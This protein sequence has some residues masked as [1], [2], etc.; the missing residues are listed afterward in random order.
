VAS[1]NAHHRSMTADD[2]S[3]VVIDRDALHIGFRHNDD[4]SGFISLPGSVASLSAALS[5]AAM[6]CSLPAPSQL[7]VIGPKSAS[8]ALNIPNA[9]WLSSPWS[10]EGAAP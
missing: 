1:I 10:M 4:W 9:Q 7:Y 3:C 2:A 5:D 8:H 6:L